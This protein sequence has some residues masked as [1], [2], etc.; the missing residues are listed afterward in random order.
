MAERSALILPIA[1]GALGWLLTHYVERV[2]ASPTVEYYVDRT[3]CDARAESEQT[4]D[5]R[6][7]IT[8]LSRTTSFPVIRFDFEGSAI[9]DFRVERVAT[10]HEGDRQPARDATTVTFFL[11]S[12]MPGAAI[13]LIV[14]A[15]GQAPTMAARSQA[16][17]RMLPA[18][19][20]TFLVRREMTIMSILVI[21]GILVV[22]WIFL[23]RP[24]KNGPGQT[25]QRH[26]VL[27]KDPADK[28]EGPAAKQEG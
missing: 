13:V 5:Y 22:G 9:R 4:C 20:E 18:N 10:A 1:L 3:N 14:R 7:A 17:L 27:F 16:P 2:T 12:L 19:F 6:H 11:E 8:N 26:L 25:M 24:S 28:Q 15:T 21:L 23:R